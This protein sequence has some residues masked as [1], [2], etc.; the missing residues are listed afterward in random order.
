MIDRTVGS[1]S[2]YAQT[3]PRILHLL[4]FWSISLFSPSTDQRDL[5]RGDPTL[6]SYALPPI[7][8]VYSTCLFHLPVLPVCSVCLFR[9]PVPSACSV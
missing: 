8:P 6:Q 3:L 4:I 1:R 7:P 2:Q 5:D 9:L